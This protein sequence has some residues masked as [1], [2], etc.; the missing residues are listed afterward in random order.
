M[1]II[2][3]FTVLIRI[4]LTCFCPFS[5]ITFPPSAFIKPADFMPSPL[6]TG[7]ILISIICCFLIRFNKNLFCSAV[8]NL[9]TILLRWG[10]FFKCAGQKTFRYEGNIKIGNNKVPAINIKKITQFLENTKKMVLDVYGH[11]LMYID[12]F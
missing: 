3:I 9:N 7:K 2:T 4:P 1:R 11:F 8:L 10:R 12:I 5:F 6:W